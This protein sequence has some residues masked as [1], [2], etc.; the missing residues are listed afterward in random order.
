MRSKSFCTPAVTELH[1][2]WMAQ[3]NACCGKSH[4]PYIQ[5]VEWPFRMDTM[6]GVR[7]EL[8]WRRTVCTAQLVARMGESESLSYN[9]RASFGDG[10]KMNVNI[11]CFAYAR[12]PC[13]SVCYSDIFL[14]YDQKRWPTLSMSFHFSVKSSSKIFETNGGIDRFSE[15]STVLTLKML[16][17]KRMK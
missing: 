4:I 2:K 15:L 1:A 12:I 7:Y 9:A 13:A 5:A 6:L 11:E 10:R 14:P 17:K 8:L 16:R 3:V